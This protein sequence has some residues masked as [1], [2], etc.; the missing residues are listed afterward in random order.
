MYEDRDFTGFLGSL[1]QCFIILVV[2][3]CSL[4]LAR[5]FLLQAVTV[6]FSLSAGDLLENFDLIITSYFS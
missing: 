6:G 5:I 4:C 2:K 1:A 3:N